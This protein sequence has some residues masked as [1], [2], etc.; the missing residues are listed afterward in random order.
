[1]GKKSLDWDKIVSKYYSKKYKKD[2]ST[3][4]CSRW[5]V[6][7]KNFQTT[8]AMFLAAAMDGWCIVVVG[9]EKTN[10]DWL[11][12]SK[13][14]KDNDSVFYFSDHGQKEWLNIPGE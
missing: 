12:S 14:L 9:D 8:E 2:Q 6:V 1:M 4:N 13:E 3:K 10:D 11:T 7:T 5:S